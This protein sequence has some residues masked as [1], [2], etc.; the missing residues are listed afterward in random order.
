MEPSSPWKGPRVY[1]VN[2]ETGTRITLDLSTGFPLSSLALALITLITTTG[3]LPD[4]S[5]V[6]IYTS[7]IGGAAWLRAWREG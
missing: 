5:G 1:E 6:W 3:S 2:A 7:K 4:I